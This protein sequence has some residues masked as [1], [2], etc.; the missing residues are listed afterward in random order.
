M[1]P[2]K[3]SRQPGL[4]FV[5][6]TSQPPYI[7]IWKKT[8]GYCSR[9]CACLDLHNPQQC[10]GHVYE[11]LP[12]TN[13]SQLNKS[14]TRKKA[15]KNVINSGHMTV[16]ESWTKNTIYSGHFVLRGTHKPLGPMVVSPLQVIYSYCVIW[17]NKD[18]MYE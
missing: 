9:V 1:K 15:E 11:K 4:S 17:T 2:N 6:K 14:H 10:S 8:R 3:Q 7:P 12:L 5:N 16:L 18:L 13:L